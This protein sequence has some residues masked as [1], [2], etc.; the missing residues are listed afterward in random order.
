MK[1]SK[2]IANF[3]WHGN[4][5]SLYEISCLTSFVKHNWEVRLWTFGGIQAPPGVLL[6]DA[7]Q[8]FKVEDIQ[9]FV[10]KKKVGCLAAFS[11]A[12]RY[13]VLE[14]DGGWWFDT[15]C[16][17]LK[18]Q[19]YFS[20]LSADKNIIAGYESSEVING[21]VLNI[22]NKTILLS[23]KK[24]LNEILEIRN[25]RVGWG[26]IG[27]RLITQIVKVYNLENEIL[28]SEY[29]YPV[30]PK[31]ALMALDADKLNELTIRSKNSYV[32]HY[33]SEMISRA[34]VNKNIL[35]PAGSFLHKLFTE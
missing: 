26:E 4:P 24:L 7:D 17:C 28:S 15:D 27:P 8:F 21:A 13:S 18:D 6:C 10:Q 25:R 33:W 32:Y 22:P 35:P 9:T 31:Q 20:N 16:V 1:T 34:G 30:T 3:F 29:F 19:S 2:E 11:D 12:F 14:R 5:L 23:T